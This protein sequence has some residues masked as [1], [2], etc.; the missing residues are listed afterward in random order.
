MT[1]FRDAKQLPTWAK[2]AIEAVYQ[3]GIMQGRDSGNFDPTSHVTRAEMAK[4]LAKIVV[5]VT[6]RRLSKFYRD[7]ESLNGSLF[8]FFALNMI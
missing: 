6:P 5:P 8:L 7:R 1:D 3:A 4:V 2:Q